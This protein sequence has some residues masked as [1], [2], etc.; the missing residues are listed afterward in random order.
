MDFSIS[1]EQKLSLFRDMETGRKRLSKTYTILQEERNIMKKRLLATFITLCLIVGLFPISASAASS[2]PTDGATTI[3]V[4]NQGGG[5]G[6]SEEKPTTLE[7]ALETINNTEPDTENACK[8]IISITEDIERTG[9]TDFYFKNHIITL[10]GN[11]HT[12]CTSGTIGAVENA[13]LYLGKADGSDSL[14]L[15]ELQRGQAHSTVSAGN[16]ASEGTVYMYDGVSIHGA[17]DAFE[18]DGTGHGVGVNKGEFHMHGGEISG[19]CIPQPGAGIIVNNGRF[20]MYGGVIQNCMSQ[21]GTQF[22]GGAIWGDGESE[23]HILGGELRNNRADNRGGAIATQGTVAIEIKGNAKIVGN[24]ANRGGAI[25]IQNSSSLIIA[26]EV[27]FSDNSC[28]GNGGAISALSGCAVT[29]TGG[30]FENNSSSSGY[31]GAI[32]HQ[33]DSAGENKSLTV[34]DTV[35]TGNQATY[36]GA[37][38]SLGGAGSTNPLTAVLTNC[39]FKGNSAHCYETENEEGQPVTDGGFGGA[40]YMQ[41]VKLTLNN[42]KIENNTAKNSGGGVYFTGNDSN[43]LALNVKGATKIWDNTAPKAKNLYLLNITSPESQEGGSQT[44]EFQTVLTV[45]DTLTTAGDQAKIGIYMDK[46]GVFTSGYSQYCG[47]AEPSA[48]FKSDHLDYHVEW[49]DEKSEATL[50]AGATEHTITATAGENGNISPSGSVTVAEGTNQTFTITPA[51]GYHIEDVLV[52]GQSIGAVSSYTFEKVAGNHTI[53]ATFDRNS[54]GGGTTRYT[55]TASAGTGGEIAPGGSVRVARGSDK[56]FTVTPAD[57][58]EISDVLVDGESVG[59]VNRYT[60]ENVRAS[61]TIEAVFEKIAQVAD[62]DETGVSDWLNTKDHFAYL[63]GYDTGFFGATNNMTRAEAAQMFYN[64]LLDKD[65]P[66]TA[67]FTDVPADAWYAKAV[68][69]LASLG[70]VEGIGNNQFAPDRAITRAEFTVIAMRF[71]ELDASGEN[72]FTDVSAD[73]WFYAQVVGSIQ[74]GW[75]TGY[76]DGTF[77]PYNTITRAEVTTIVNRMLGRAADEDYVDNHADE[78]RQFPD[79]SQTNWAYYNIVE[80]TNA[81]DYSKSGGTETWKSL[82]K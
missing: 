7:S 66:M 52:D 68:R 41:D 32:Y 40:L 60:F 21:G 65:V 29:I 31:G 38:L 69:T 24:K 9:T 70:I 15:K 13:V 46:P 54:S 14:T 72:I 78:L 53:S 71:A 27:E 26:D 10:L 4:S 12:V 59:A 42:C 16:G 33:R 63:N 28:V 25:S 82:N 20:Y 35:F 81:H 18:N 55:I 58:Y 39:I 79:V 44:D 17:S 23:I 37:V 47:E 34:Q 73:D 62:P 43:L 49:N 67:S 19:F 57:G 5:D 22:G 50:E 3:Y 1:A 6:T 61:H 74:Y 8:F 76:E 51:G 64:L 2:D 11:G 75:I 56:T 36:G 30:I 77:R 45:S 48:Y 80:A